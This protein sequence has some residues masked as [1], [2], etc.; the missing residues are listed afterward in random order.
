[1]PQVK[2]SAEELMKGIIKVLNLMKNKSENPAK[3][4]IAVKTIERE[5]KTDAALRKVSEQ[6]LSKYKNIIKKSIDEG[7]LSSKGVDL[8]GW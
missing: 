5:L 3:T 2:Q 8:R 4:A 6:D 1:M 7:G